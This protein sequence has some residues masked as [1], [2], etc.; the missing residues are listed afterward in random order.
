MKRW[1]ARIVIGCLLCQGG[2]ATQVRAQNKDYPAS[3]SDLVLNPVSTRTPAPDD[4]YMRGTDSLTGPD[5]LVGSAIARDGMRRGTHN[6]VYTEPGELPFVHP[7]HCPCCIDET[8]VSRFR[9]GFYQ[10]SSLSGGI[11][12]NDSLAQTHYDVSTRFGIPIDGMSNTLIIAPSFRHEFLDAPNGV[13]LPNELFV[14]GVNFTWLYR[15]NERWSATSMVTPSIRSDFQTSEEAFRLFG[16]G[17]LTYQWI[18]KKLDVSFGAVYLDRDDIPLL[19]V[20]GFTWSPKP[21]WRIEANFPR[22]RIARRLEKYGGEFE[23]WIYTGVALG[24]NTYAV[25]RAGGND[26]VLNLRDFQWVLGWEHLRSGGR[27]IFAE[28]G[29]VFGRTAEYENVPLEIDFDNS[30]FARIGITM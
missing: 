26:D 7:P 23:S 25:E 13:D 27:G 14:T 4:S 9:N 29:A 12:G 18:P 19:P 3:P 6:G 11:L 24:G 30:L 21:W 8:P 1:I 10:G 20:L 17:M 2:Q 5:D 28:V 22:P 16:L 15:I